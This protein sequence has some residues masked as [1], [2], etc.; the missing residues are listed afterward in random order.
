[1]A[2]Q[3]QN[4]YRRLILTAL[5][6]TSLAVVL[7]AVLLSVVLD[8]PF[9]VA[10]WL[11]LANA[12]WRAGADW[13]EPMTLTHVNTDHCHLHLDVRR[14]GE[15]SQPVGVR[16]VVRSRSGRPVVGARVKVAGMTTLT[17]ADGRFFLQHLLTPGEYPLVVTL[18][19]GRT[20]TRR[21]SLVAQRVAR[22][23]VQE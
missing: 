19:N 16:G 12:A 10:D 2:G 15:R 6:A 11:L 21:V 1:M 4:G 9:D 20:L 13:I 5:L 14:S 22:V 23:V 3:G 18:P 7:W 8:R 17:G